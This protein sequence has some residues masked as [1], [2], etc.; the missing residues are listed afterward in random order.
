MSW[1]NPVTNIGSYRAPS[2]TRRTNFDPDV[3]TPCRPGL[4][5]RDRHRAGRTESL[6]TSFATFQESI[7]DQLDRM[8]GAGGFDPARDIIA[9]TAD[10]WPPGQAY[11]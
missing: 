6:G 10:G 1:R 5:E 3:R 7:R 2:F 8:L 9:I 4:P 11:E